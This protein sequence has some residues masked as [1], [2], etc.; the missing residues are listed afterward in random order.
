V[1]SAGLAVLASVLWGTSD[2]AAGLLARRTSLW[3]VVTFTQVGGLAAGAVVV[4]V[5]GRPF[6]EL[7]AVII[8]ALTGLC[9]IVAIVSFYKALAIGVM[10]LVAPL[11]ATGIVVPVIVGLARG[12]RPSALQWAGMALAVAGVVFASLEPTHPVGADPPAVGTRTAA[13]AG[14][15]SGVRA[16]IRAAVYAR[17]SIVLA[18]VAALTIGA[19]YVG[20]AEAARYD[21]YWSVLIMRGTT[22]PLVLIALASVRPTLGLAVGVVP[23][24]MAVGACDVAANMLYSVAS[25]GALLAV[26]SVLG[27]LFPVVTVVLAHGLLHERLTRLQQIGAATALV[28][29]LLMV[30]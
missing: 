10:S 6:P 28:G 16:S 15:Q 8:S 5:H 19:S 1:F 17:L 25:T 18:L 26:V 30:V 21:A 12:D 22:L 2:F 27:Y 11:A 9:G 13:A 4:A 24:M 29:A 7:A 3:A 20:L 23:I 14:R